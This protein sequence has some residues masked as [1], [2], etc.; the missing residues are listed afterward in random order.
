MCEFDRA[1]FL[2]GKQLMYFERY[3]K[4]FLADAPILA[5]QA[6]VAG[7]LRGAPRASTS[8]TPGERGRTAVRAAPIG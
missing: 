1:N 5:D 2:L 7:L 3:G 8:R 6:F 4:L